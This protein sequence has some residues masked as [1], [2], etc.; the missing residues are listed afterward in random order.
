M[1][2]IQSKTVRELRET[3]RWSGKDRPLVAEISNGTLCLR[4]KGVRA[5]LLPLEIGGLYLKKFAEHQG[6]AAPP[7]NTKGRKVKRS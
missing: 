1:S 7:A 4:V 6:V 3:V 2:V 5:P